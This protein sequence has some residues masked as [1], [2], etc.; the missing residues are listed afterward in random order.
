MKFGITVAAIG[1]E[2]GQPRG[3]PQV[4]QKSVI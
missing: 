2:K 3:W 1:K 4:V